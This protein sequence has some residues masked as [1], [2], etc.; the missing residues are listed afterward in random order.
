MRLV[1]WDRLLLQKLFF[2]WY[3]CGFKMGADYNT[4]ADISIA[5]TVHIFDQVSDYFLDVDI[6]FI[7]D[8]QFNC[9]CGAGQ[10]VQNSALF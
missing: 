3:L 1:V 7:P 10:A 9:T 8:F 6:I 4:R 2:K 5:C